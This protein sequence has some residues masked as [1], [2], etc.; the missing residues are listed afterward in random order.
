M[1]SSTFLSSNLTFHYP[2]DKIGSEKCQLET[3]KC[4]LE[5]E[6]CPVGTEKCLASIA[7][8]ERCHNTT[9]HCSFVRYI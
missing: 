7:K 5:R 2:V 6:K 9:A 8:C 1:T 3:K 4:Q